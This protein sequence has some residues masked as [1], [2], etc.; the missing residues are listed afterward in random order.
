MSM[1]ARMK[2]NGFKL[3]QEKRFILY[4]KTHNI[5]SQEW[6]ETDLNVSNLPWGKRGSQD[7][8]P[9]LLAL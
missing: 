6:L 5:M 8:L 1:V 2:I 9:V 3:Q 7:W 4:V